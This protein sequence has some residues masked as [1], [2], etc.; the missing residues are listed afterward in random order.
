MTTRRA[1]EH[2]MIVASEELVKCVR[3]DMT[4]AG[5]NKHPKWKTVFEIDH[6]PTKKLRG[7]N[8]DD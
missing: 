6:R 4:K 5:L 7:E 3:R 2:S 1:R 8:N